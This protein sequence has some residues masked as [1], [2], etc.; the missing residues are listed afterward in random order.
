M[1]GGVGIRMAVAAT[2]TGLR[3]QGGVAGA[4]CEAAAAESGSNLFC[5]D[6]QTLQQKWPTIFVECFHAYFH[7]IFH[8]Y[9]HEICMSY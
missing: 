8:A 2:S 7:E 6:K 3:R 1:D 5:T 9:F 4:S